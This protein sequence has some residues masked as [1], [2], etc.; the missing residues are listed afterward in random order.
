MADDL[1]E[2]MKL[3]DEKLQTISNSNYPVVGKH[4]ERRAVAKAQ[5]E[6]CLSLLTSG[7]GFELPPI[8]TMPCHMSQDAEGLKDIEGCV[9]TAFDAPTCDSCLIRLIWEAATERQSAIQPLIAQNKALADKVVVLEIAGDFLATQRD[10]AMEE[11][12]TWIKKAWDSNALVS[13]QMVQI[14]DLL[15][16]VK[17]LKAEVERLEALL[18]TPVEASD[19]ITLIKWVQQ[20]KTVK[21]RRA[22]KAFIKKLEA[23]AA[24]SSKEGE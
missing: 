3:T 21:V 10:K 5:V 8:P 18:P 16:E 14:G 11:T 9:F 1:K 22:G 2:K 15:G 20:D 4:S 7:E 23:I 12:A 19:T 6:K 24:L 13:S 17:A